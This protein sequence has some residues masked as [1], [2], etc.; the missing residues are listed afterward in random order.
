MSYIAL[1]NTK[2]RY[3]IYVL[4]IH[5]HL[6]KIIVVLEAHEK[7]SRRA[8]YSVYM[9]TIHLKEDQQSVLNGLNHVDSAI[10]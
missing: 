5:A 7:C 3:I 1:L 4:L 8:Q 9:Y 6:N 2:I 10:K